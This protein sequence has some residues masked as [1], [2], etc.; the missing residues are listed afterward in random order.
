MLKRFSIK[1]LKA[2][3]DA[4]TTRNSLNKLEIYINEY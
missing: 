3:K 2:E 4:E 1:P